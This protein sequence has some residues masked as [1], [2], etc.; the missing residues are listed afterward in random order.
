M[1]PNT[2]SI[3][4]QQTP[5]NEKKANVDMQKEHYKKCAPKISCQEIA[6]VYFFSESY[7]LFDTS[8][9]YGHSSGKNSI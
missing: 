8:G 3:I 5:R 6:I 7:K 4:L 1:I 9:S 2:S